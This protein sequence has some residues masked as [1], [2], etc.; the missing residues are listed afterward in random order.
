MLF[1][2]SMIIYYESARK[3]TGTLLE[4]ISEFSTKI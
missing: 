3:L 2:G 1:I 4:Q